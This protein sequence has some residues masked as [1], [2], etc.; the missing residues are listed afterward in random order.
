MRDPNHP[1]IV[2]MLSGCLKGEVGMELF[3]Q[4]LAQ[5]I[6]DNQ[7]LVM[8][9]LR[10]FNCLKDKGVSS[11]PLFSN[12]HGKPMTVSELDGPFHSILDKVQ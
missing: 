1:H 11:G 9:Y 7:N 4:P 2:L 5:Q 8:W 12:K 6:K 10:L 3:Y